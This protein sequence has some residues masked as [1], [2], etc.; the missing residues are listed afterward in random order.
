M[1]KFNFQ[2]YVPQRFKRKSLQ[3]EIISAFIIILIF[4]I[5]VVF[6]LVVAQNKK[7]NNLF[8]P[9]NYYFVYAYKYRKESMLNSKK[10]EVKKLGGANEIYLHRNEHY[11]IVNVFLKKQE[12][13]N[14]LKNIKK[15]FPNAG[16]LRIC[17][18]QYLKESKKVIMDNFDIKNALKRTEINNNNIF[19]SQVKFLSNDRL[20]SDIVS[21]VSKCRLE[22]NSILKII[23][24]EDSE[25]RRIISNHIN[26]NLLYYEEF[27]EKYYAQT[28]NREHLIN[29]LSVRIALNQIKMINNMAENTKL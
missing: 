23:G 5:I 7:K 20:K 29:K 16:I 10:E 2:V 3:I 24:D 11:L 14:L 1:T 28:N 27:F 9:L 18:N 17:S 19:N 6:I 12:A 13:E 15:E 8:L 4:L 21:M 25:I 22:S 26:I